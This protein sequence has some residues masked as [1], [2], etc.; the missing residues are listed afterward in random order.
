MTF[1]FNWRE[2]LSWICDAVQL[3]GSG[4]FVRR[5]KV[6]D[7]DVQVKGLLEEV[8]FARTCGKHQ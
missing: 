6:L 2:M 3:K 5:N 1:E 8:P 4:M 7:L